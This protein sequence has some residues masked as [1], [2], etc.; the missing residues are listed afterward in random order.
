MQTRSKTIDLRMPKSPETGDIYDI[1]ENYIGMWESVIFPDIITPDEYR[2]MDP[3]I[4]LR[5]YITTLSNNP[6]LLTALV[7]NSECSISRLYN[8]KM[9]NKKLY[10]TALRFVHRSKMIAWLERSDCT[11]CSTNHFTEMTDHKLCALLY[12][13][14]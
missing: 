1:I 7:N 8:M 13:K 14:I 6:K 11:P 3:K 12:S 9:I 5:L 10:C 2:N 4:C